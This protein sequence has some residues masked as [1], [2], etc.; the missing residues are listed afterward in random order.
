[1]KQ[2]FSVLVLIALVTV[3]CKKDKAITEELYVPGDLII[4]ITSN[5]DLRTV[6]DTLNLLDLKIERMNGFS[7][8]AN[9][10]AD[11]LMP[12]LAYLNTKT[13][14]NTGTGWKANGY[15]YEPENAIRVLFSF[16]DM[17]PTNQVDF[18]TTISSL[19]LIDRQGETKN[20]HIK[21]Q[22]GTEKYWLHELKKYQFIKWTELNN[23]GHVNNN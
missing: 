10:P 23:F 21:V 22:E 8:N 16:F 15:F 2:L 14:I 17:S 20:M 19:N 11:S 3:S 7:Y 12:L 6:F 4:G 13:Y 1:M 5:A 18:L 9:L